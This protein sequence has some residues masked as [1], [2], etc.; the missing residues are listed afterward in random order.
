MM[1]KKKLCIIIVIAII[2]PGLAVTFAVLSKS[3]KHKESVNA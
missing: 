1:N 3:G 2:V